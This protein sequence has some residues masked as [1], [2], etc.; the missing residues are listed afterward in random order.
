MIITN[1]NNHA[2]SNARPSDMITKI[3]SGG[4]TGADQAALDAAIKIG[5][6][7]GGWIPKG[8]LTEDGPLD[9]RYKLQEMPTK[10]YPARTKQNITD[11]DGTVIISHGRLT[12]G[13]KLTFDHAEKH[14]KPCLHVDL[15]ITPAFIASSQISTWA[16]AHNVEILNVAGPRGSKDPDIYRDTF[17]VIEGALLL[18]LV[19]A[20]YDQTI[21]DYTNEQLLE[22]LPLPPKTV[23]DAVEL[24]IDGM[25]LRDRNRIANMEIDGLVM[26]HND[27]GTY[28]KDVFRLDH[29]NEEILESCRKIARQAVK[30]ADDIAAVIVGTLYKKLKDTHKL[31]IV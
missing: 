26:L 29:D 19:D 22:N 3:I 16:K 8:R 25:T 2:D 4:Q 27:L 9:D 7:H 30:D 6:P 12:G 23:D 21:N 18:S 31:R 15:N 17:Y 28:M 24:L 1:D 13:S 20:K 14:L 11:S 10:S 5:V